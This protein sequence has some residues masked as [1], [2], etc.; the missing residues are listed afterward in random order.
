M[1]QSSFDIRSTTLDD[2]ETL[3]QLRI[4]FLREIGSC[5]QAQKNALTEATQTYFRNKMPTREFMA[6]IAEAQGRII[7]TSGVV[8]FERPP[9]A[10]NLSGKEIYIMNMYTVP[11]WRC[12][13]VAT[14]LLQKILCFAEQKSIGRIWLHSTNEGRPIYL[15]C[16]FVGTSTE[17]ELIMHTHT[18][19]T[20]DLLRREQVL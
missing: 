3:V 15:K 8:L 7:G 4:D 18:G 2:L 5:N 14:T 19:H 10:E 16:G 20:N 12:Q 11:E 6:W 1:K 13:G 17:M 9:V